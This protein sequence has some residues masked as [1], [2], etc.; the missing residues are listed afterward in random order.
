MS[1]GRFVKYSDYAALKQERD[2]LLTMNREILDE[3]KREVERLE[4]T[5]RKIKQRAESARMEAVD[6]GEWWAED[7]LG[8]IEN[9]CEAA[10]HPDRFHEGGN[11]E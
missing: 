5:I 4:A 3:G 1:D 10:L 6:E 9:M 8:V 7:H 11:D 2:E